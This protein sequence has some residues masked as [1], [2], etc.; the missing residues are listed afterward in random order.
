MKCEKCEDIHTDPKTGK[1]ICFKCGL[2]VEESLID[3]DEV[4]Y[5]ES[6]NVSGKFVDDDTIHIYPR[7]NT[8]NKMNGHS[9]KFLKKIF[10]EMEKKAEMLTIESDTLKI[11]KK[12]YKIASKKK[13]TLGRKINIVIETVLYLACRIKEKNVLLKDFADVF[14]VHLSEIGSTYIKLLKFFKKKTKIEIINKIKIIDP[15][16]F[17]QRFC[18]KINLGNKAKEVEV[19]AL[20]ILQ[21]MKRDW[22]TCARNPSGLC[23]ACILISAKLHNLKIDINNISKIVRS[24]PNTIFNRIKEFSLTKIASMTKEEFDIFKDSNFYP[25]ADP[26][27]FLK[28]LKKEDNNEKEIKMQNKEKKENSQLI[29]EN[30]ANNMNNNSFSFSSQ[31]PKLELNKDYSFQKDLFNLNPSISNLSSFTFKQKKETNKNYQF[32]S[33]NLKPENN[34]LNLKNYFCESFT[35]KPA[36]SGIS[37]NSNINKN[38]LSFKSNNSRKSKSRII[39]ELKPLKVNYDENLS[40]IPD[41]EDYKYI[42][43]KDEYE[44]RKQF[45]EIMF[46]DWLAQKKEKEEKGIK[47]NKIKSPIKDNIN[48]INEKEEFF[49]ES[50]KTNKNLNKKINYSLIKKMLSK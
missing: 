23:G 10:D 38:I 36:E 12:Y 21:F 27:A 49:Y 42:F 34:E 11:A 26:P 41:N 31:M 20:K 5:D 3:V 22:I 33:F 17:I 37:K 24:S 28:N 8:L 48:N 43:S 50:I 19:V 13:F 9:Q 32:E 14:N 18:N 35:L 4:E 1:S 2:E 6:Q 44:V 45:W 25:G 47:E 16:L 29:N 30:N 15:S 39:N 7:N 40:N 46:K